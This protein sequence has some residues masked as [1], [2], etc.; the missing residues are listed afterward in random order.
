M[1]L[2]WC[3]GPAVPGSGDPE[4]HAAP[5]VSRQKTRERQE[6]GRGRCEREGGVHGL[7][8]CSDPE[9]AAVPQYEHADG[10]QPHPH[11]S[12]RRRAHSSGSSS[13]RAQSSRL[14]LL[15]LLSV[16]AA[17]VPH[18]PSAAAAAPT[19]SSTNQGG[20][21]ALGECRP[22]RPKGWGEERR[23]VLVHAAR[24]VHPSFFWQQPAGERSE[25]AE[26]DSGVW[27]PQQ[28]RCGFLIGTQVFT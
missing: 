13:A 27:L 21:V 14:L 23:G 5:F 9:P 17:D 7:C 20:A 22:T 25:K 11:H 3:L 4:V 2:S 6:H 18:L 19:T 12:A 16:L 8:G 1:V 28:K 10:P 26:E 24:S 15:P